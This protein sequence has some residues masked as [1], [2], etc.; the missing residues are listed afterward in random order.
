LAV[1]PDYASRFHTFR[2]LQGSLLPG[3]VVLDQ[4]LASTLQARIGDRV[5]LVVRAHA[6][7]QSFKV[8]GI[9]VVT[10]A[11]KL[12]QPLDP[13]AGPA[14]A[15]PPANVAVMP[16]ATF[17]QSLAPSLHAIT[18]SNAGSSAVPGAQQG[19]QWQV[20]AQVDQR[21]LGN[22][23]SQAL[24]QAEQLR[25]RAERSLPG[26]VQF[27]DN[28]AEQLTTASGD[29]LYAEALYIML[30]VPGALIALGL[31]YLA[32]LG[33]VER[34]RR[35]LALL[36]ARGASRRDLIGLAA[37]ESGVIGLLAGLVGAGL[38]FVATDTLVSGGIDTSATRAVV[39]VL[40]CLAL[41]IGGAL[42]ARLAAT[43]SVWRASVVAA[44]RSAQRESR[45][46]W[47]KLY[48][49]LVCLV[50]GGL[51]YWLTAST[52]FSAVVNPD[53]NPTLS[54]SVYMFFAPALLWIGAALLLVRLRGRLLGRGLALGRRV[55]GRGTASGSSFIL[56]SAARRGPAINR[57]LLAVGLLL[58]F[59]V[60]LGIFA[61]TYNQQ[62]NVDAQLTLGADVVATAPPGVAQQ[63]NLAAKVAHVPGVAGTSAVEHS[64]AYVGPDLQDTYGIDAATLTR[65]TTL[66]DSYFIGDTAQGALARL[67]ATP[68]GILVSKE[69]IKDYSVNRGDLLRL[70]VL[71]RQTSKFG[72]VNFH[73]AGIVQEFPSAPKDS[74]MVAN[75]SYLQAADHGGGAN[76]V[77]AKA[78]GDP[79]AVARR[80]AAATGGEG[81]QVKNIRQ[82]SAQTVSSITTVDLSGVTA[83]E[84][85]F[86]ILLAGAAMALLIALGMYERRHEFATMAAVGASVR[87]IAAYV[88][89]EAAIVLLAAAAL[90][91]VLG[92]LLAEMLVAM[93][94]HVF[95]PPPD[96]LAVPWGF[97][98]GMFGAA[99]VAT[100]IAVVVAG[101]GLRRLPLGR[102]LREE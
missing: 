33:T 20:Q 11:D 81:T 55:L 94:Q 73:V 10:A 70:R 37:I 98:A 89:S 60:N 93:L 56:A 92:W 74:F 64:Y 14:P 9:A 19:I 5:S 53:S 51:I 39:A 88:W 97:L 30:A 24:T 99:A 68:D 57:G 71:D 91:A 35:D 65:A 77:F 95:D 34:D 17:A 69:T 15:Q 42:V 61:A 49:D 87:E 25:R 52:G 8:S 76:V 36:R 72:V 32:A 1:P 26:Q 28:L 67:R 47:Q 4:Q 82:Q 2:F 80:V 101:R 63:H 31:A 29:A 3:Q 27:V 50:A 84:R 45:P 6:P 22:S 13:R 12:F 46:L 90:A 21:Q 66:R 100:L 75:L 40:A 18:Q 86:V 78:S 102:L 62:V 79:P 7:P 83:I 44:R 85:A 41:A 38:A 58:A 96:H 23:P 16:I 59:G 43:A 48:V 54:L